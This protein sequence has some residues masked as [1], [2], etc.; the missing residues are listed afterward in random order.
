MIRNEGCSK[1]PRWQGLEDP[2]RTHK[3]WGRPPGERSPSRDS[4]APRPRRSDAQNPLPSP[5]LPARRAGGVPARGGAAGGR[6]RRIHPG[7]SAESGRRPPYQIPR[8]RLVA[9]LHPGLGAGI[10]EGRSQL[11][12]PATTRFSSVQGECHRGNSGENQRHAGYEHPPPRDCLRV[13]GGASRVVCQADAFVF[14]MS[15]IAFIPR[16]SL[17]PTIGRSPPSPGS[18]P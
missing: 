1:T 2:V 12:G 10:H 13:P 3:C 15:W 5:R 18:S 16:Q 11:H 14:C 9:P 8:S 7:P 4:A 17:S 6:A